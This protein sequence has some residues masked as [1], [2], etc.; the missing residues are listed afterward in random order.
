[1]RLTC[2]STRQ[3]QRRSGSALVEFAVVAPILMIFILGILE[4][5]R[6]VM[7][8][9]I[10]TNASREGARYAVQ[11][12][13]NTAAIDSYLRTYLSAAGLSNTASGSNS[14]VTVT[15]ESYSGSAWTT[16]AD[17]STVASGSPIRV[18][19]AV[20]FNSQSWLPT[21]FFVGNNKQVQ[22]VTVMRRE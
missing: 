20:N 1:M 11:G 7:V 17:P 6:L 14:A 4:I 15:V 12:D 16:T 3:R 9:Q 18:T 5:G 22:G 2:V 19:V 21:R 8:A 10:T 13:A